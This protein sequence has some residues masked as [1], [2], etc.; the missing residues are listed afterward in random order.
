MRAEGRQHGIVDII[1]AILTTVGSLVGDD[2]V[3]GAHHRLHCGTAFFAVGFLRWCQWR[4][5]ALWYAVIEKFR[6][7]MAGVEIPTAPPDKLQVLPV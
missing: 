7:Q 5:T 1:T 6:R 2:A 3:H 4:G